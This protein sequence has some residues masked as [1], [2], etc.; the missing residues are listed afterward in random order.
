MGSSSSRERADSNIQPATRRISHIV[1]TPNKKEKISKKEE[2]TKKKTQNVIKTNRRW[3]VQPPKVIKASPVKHKAKVEANIVNSIES[4]SQIPSIDE[5]DVMDYNLNKESLN[6]DELS[7]EAS[8]SK[9][10]LD[11]L[12][13]NKYRVDS[14]QSLEVLSQNASISRR[15]MRF[16]KRANRGSMILAGINTLNTPQVRDSNARYSQRLNFEEISDRNRYTSVQQMGF[17]NPYS[18]QGN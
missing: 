4:M 15:T 8:K 16:I 1:G 6:M 12:R 11:H 7:R 14:I 3:T 2:K 17:L 5:E 18:F 10:A 13:K 9:M